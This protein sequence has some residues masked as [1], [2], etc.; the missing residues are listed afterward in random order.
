MPTGAIKRFDL[1]KGFGF[2]AQDSGGED[3]FLHIS[4]FQDATA[5]WLL[6]PGTLIEFSIQTG[7][8]GLR[9]TQAKV[10]RGAPSR[11]FQRLLARISRFAVVS[12]LATPPRMIAKPLRFA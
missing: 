12:S 8:K 9:A 4:D 2:V 6:E 1:S 3:V 7:P 10:P 5:A 11:E